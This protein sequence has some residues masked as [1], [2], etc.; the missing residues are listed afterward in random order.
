MDDIAQV[1][2]QVRDLTT[3][4]RLMNQ[5]EIN[6]NFTQITVQKYRIALLVGAPK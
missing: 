6:H 1:A 5:L 4:H 2:E 3:E